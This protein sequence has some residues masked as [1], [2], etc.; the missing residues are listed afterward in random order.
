MC[1][2][3]LKLELLLFSRRAES[4]SVFSSGAEHEL[5]SFGANLAPGRSDSVRD[6]SL[7]SNNCTKS[8]GGSF[9]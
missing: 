8:F 1:E 7:K 4:R 2:G 9:L 6:Q 5:A 3:V